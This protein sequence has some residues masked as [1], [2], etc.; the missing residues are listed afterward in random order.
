MSQD[1]CNEWGPGESAVINSLRSTFGA[2]ANAE[3]LA[4]IVATE[5]EITIM[6]DS[7][8]SELEEAKGAAVITA[9]ILS[10]AETALRSAQ[11]ARTRAVNDMDRAAQRVK[12]LE[13]MRDQLVFQVNKLGQRRVQ[14]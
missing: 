11:H 3:D 9:T 8:V 12:K 2:M 5:S 1:Q 6:A 4:Q 13:G 14:L 7:L 10:D